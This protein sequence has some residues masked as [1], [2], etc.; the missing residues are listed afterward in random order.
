[1]R[2]I[3][4]LCV[5]LASLTA[6]A[7]DIGMYNRA[8]SAFNAGNF[9]EAARTFWEL[10]ETSTDQ[11]I[12]A[13]S[14]Y[15]L[16]QSLARRNL[17]FAAYIYYYSILKSGPQHPFYLRAV[18]GLVNVQRE[19]ND[20]Y[21]IPTAL[22]REYNDQ[23]ATLPLEVLARI[24]YMIGIIEHRRA[25][26]EEARDFLAAVPR[27]TSIYAKARY[28]LGIVFVDPRFPGG[29]QFA[30]G[31]KAFGEV[32][33]LSGER[34]EGLVET[35]QLA[36][37]ALGRTYYGMGEYQNSVNAYERV[38]RFS[39]YWD[40]A[41]FENGFARFQN[42]D[43]GG[44]LGSLQALHAPQFAGAFQ[45][46]SW[47]L[48]ATVYYFSCLYEESKTALAAFDER[49]LPM[50]EAIR[51][52]LDGDE[53]R[54]MSY[55]YQLV[56]GAE[57]KQLPRPV[58]LW[59]RGNERM[60]GLFGMLSQIDREKQAITANTAWQG[61]KMG[62]DII[63]YLDQNRNTVRQVAGDV[64][65][66]RLQEAGQNIRTYSDASEIIRFETTKSEKELFEAGVDQSQILNAQNLYRPQTPAENWNY[67][68]FQG[69]F[70]I[71]E[72]GY[73]QYTLKRGCPQGQQ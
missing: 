18:E 57:S 34:Y 37:L 51:K 28:L 13:R 73:Y 30:D 9:D 58:L 54:D 62:P 1:M 68:R 61:S 32:Q 65:K 59:V 66:K 4:V 31:I 25:R 14:E 71:D 63:N 22:N 64:A 41:L 69:E 53:D 42:D 29:P 33:N 20:Q 19:L 3:L 27:E 52:V 39:R 67:W 55:Y 44:A 60:L 46:E 21:L 17:P 49:Y 16:A 5:V 43:Y 7:Q 56:A 24:N 35:Q 38:P 50:G 23:W 8:L 2:T 45:P 40:Q 70:W 11:D 48:K 26:F 10:S 47:I 12:R 72:I 36:T 6:G 15:Y